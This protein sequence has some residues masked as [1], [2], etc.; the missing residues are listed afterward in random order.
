MEK[1][2]GIFYVPRFE[3]VCFPSKKHTVPLR[4]T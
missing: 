4:E 3:T 1:V 2:F